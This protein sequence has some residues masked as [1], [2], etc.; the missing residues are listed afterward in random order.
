[1]V[2]FPFPFTTPFILF[3]RFLS[4]FIILKC[5]FNGY[6]KFTRGLA[7]RDSL[8]VRLKIQHEFPVDNII[9]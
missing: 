7:Q 3:L 9:C 4:S 8:Q 1:M 2:M 6:L 5:H